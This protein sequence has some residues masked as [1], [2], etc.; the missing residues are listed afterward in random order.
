VKLLKYGSENSD[1]CC[2]TSVAIVLVNTLLSDLFDSSA[3]SN[4]G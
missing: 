2:I 4:T 3:R 1:V